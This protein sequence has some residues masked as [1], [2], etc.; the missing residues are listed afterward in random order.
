MTVPSLPLR[1]HHRRSGARALRWAQ[2]GLLAGTSLMGGSLVACGSSEGGDDSTTPPFGG[3][4]G[5]SGPAG[6]GGSA[7]GPT[8][9]AGSSGVS[10]STPEGMNPNTPIVQTPTTP[11]SG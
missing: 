7:T 3:L 5:N 4:A 9:A 8:G 11:I 1:S 6:A 2:L 10:T